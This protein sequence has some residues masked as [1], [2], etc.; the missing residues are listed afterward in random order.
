MAPSN[1]AVFALASFFG[2]YLVFQI[3]PIMARQ[4]L[5]WFG[6]A[7]AVWS[8][9]LVFFQVGLVAGY[10]YAH[11]TRRLGVRRQAALHLALLTVVAV[12][13]PIQIDPDWKPDDPAG[14]AARVLGLLALSVGGPYVLLAA[15]APLL[16]DWFARALGADAPYRLYVP[17]NIGSLAGLLAYPLIVEPLLSVESQTLAWRLVLAVFVALCGWCGWVSARGRSAGAVRVDSTAPAAPRPGA[18]ALWTALAA[19]GSAL[20]VAVTNQLSQE[21]AAVPMLWVV[22]LVLYLATFIACFAE[23]YDRR[24][25]AAIF[26]LAMLGASWALAPGADASLGLQAAVLLG[27]LAAGGMLCH[28][29]LVRH[30]PD[31]AHLTTFYV[32]LAAGGSLGGGAVALGAPI[33]FDSHAELPY[34]VLL[35]PALLLISLAGERARR[36]RHAT[37]VLLWTIPTLALVAG[38]GSALAAAGS[39]ARTVA[40]ARDF[41]GV[42]RV[43]D[44]A[45]GEPRRLRGLLHGRIIHGSQYLDPR[46]RTEATTY[47][48]EGSGIEL[49]IRLHPARELARPMTVGVV[50]LGT[51]TIARWAAPGDVFRFFELSP[52]V[53]DFG[54]RYFSFLDDSAG[55]VEIVEGDAR[56]SLEREL[57]ANGSRRA[58]DVLAVDAFSGDAIPVHLMTREGLEVYRAALARDGVLAFH[59]SNQ[60]LDLRPVVRALARTMSWPAV[61]VVR[62]ADPD[63]AIQKSQWMLLT[64]NAQLLERLQPFATPDDEPG[65]SLLW[66]DSFSTIWPLLRWR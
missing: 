32:T 48:A 16:Q 31:P 66:T 23:W 1:R 54:G 4:I 44:D 59:V 25:W 60:H 11:V 9:C 8:T 14:P 51:G 45:P 7:S 37:P 21:V 62:P 55:S 26:A 10:V 18:V 29:E 65:R 52:L 39:S 46:L 30:R 42:L 17:S 63:R 64:S 35:V 41:Y 40:A 6:G 56:L 61:E 2:A 33:L 3:Q 47:Y 34:L 20:L 12:A 49:A 5:P 53:I 13:L 57:A 24:T 27:L 50:G 22:P 15:T 43:I 28:G 38:L 19:C 58:Y 36:T